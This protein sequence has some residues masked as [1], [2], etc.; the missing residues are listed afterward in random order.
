MRTAFAVLLL[1]LAGCGAPQE[2]P[3]QAE[4]VQSVAA[5]GALLAHEASEGSLAIFT[6]E[7]SKALRK[8]IGELRPAIEDGQL[9]RLA[10][11]VDR[12]LERLAADPADGS[13]AKEVEH[14]LDDAARAAEELGG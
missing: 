2:L 5:E 4:E 14:S 6:R 3:K 8:L 9:A 1:L 10:D 13:L 11:E 7:H 12:L